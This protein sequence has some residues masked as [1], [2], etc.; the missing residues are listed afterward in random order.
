MCRGDAAKPTG[1]DINAVLEQIMGTASRAEPARR[2][3][4]AVEAALTEGELDEARTQL[5][6]L[7]ALIRGDDPTVVGLEATINNV[8]AL[9]DAP[10]H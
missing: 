2:A 5:A 4:A 6:A 1:L 8:E 7:R 10:D 9:S 3:I